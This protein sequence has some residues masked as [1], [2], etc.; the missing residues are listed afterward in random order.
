M[1]SQSP[2]TFLSFEGRL[3]SDFQM[4]KIQKNVSRRKTYQRKSARSLF[5]LL[6]P[7]SLVERLFIKIHMQIQQLQPTTQHTSSPRENSA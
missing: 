1:Y 7:K 6:E 2:E 5:Q 3:A 4:R